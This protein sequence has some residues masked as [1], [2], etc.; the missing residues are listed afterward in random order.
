[1]PG[2]APQRPSLKILQILR[3]PVGGLF[4]H[5]RD[6]TE[7]LAARGHRL[8]V[9]VDSIAF[10]ALTERNL[11]ALAAH[12][13]LGIHRV[14][15]PRLFGPADL[16]APAKLRGLMAR[17]GIEIVHGH[18]AKGGFH[19]RLAVGRHPTIPVFYTPHGGVL[20]YSPRRLPGAVFLLVERRLMARTEAIFFESEFARRTWT[21]LVGSPGAAGRLVH[22]GLREEEFDPVGSSGEFDFVFV[23]ELRALKGLDVLL[24]ALTGLLRPDGKPPRLLVAGDGPDA[25]VIGVRIVNA[26]MSGQVSLAGAMPARAALARGDCVVVPSRAES[27]PYVVLEAAAAEKPLI[28]TRVGGIPEIF[29]PTEAALV[30]PDDADALRAQMQR[31][32][33]EADELRA[34]AAQRRRFVRANFDATAMADAIEDG[35]LRA[36]DQR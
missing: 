3:A 16:T 11:E 9:V 5:V 26:R 19:A 32:L 31:W 8:G 1:M 29:G 17:L 36:L 12:A 4:R 27:L 6:L 23:G 34:E 30:A 35:Y 28:A 25:E 7:M 2:E 10:D 14:A 33:T 13:T 20:H 24:T 18:G 15:M 22:N 21:A